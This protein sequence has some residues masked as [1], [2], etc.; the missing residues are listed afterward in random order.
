MLILEV[1]N[2]L[3]FGAE[4]FTSIFLPKCTVYAGI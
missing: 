4:F 1:K 2:S 3:I